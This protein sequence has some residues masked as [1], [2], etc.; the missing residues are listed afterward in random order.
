MGK[1]DPARSYVRSSPSRAPSSSHT[2]HVARHGAKELAFGVH[3]DTQEVF[4][5]SR[6]LTRSFLLNFV[7]LNSTPAHYKNLCPLYPRGTSSSPALTLAVRTLGPRL[8][9]ATRK[10]GSIDRDRLHSNPH[11][12]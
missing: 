12:H 4:I 9:L 8:H 11:L 1:H 5:L 7:A 10:N 3:E 2:L 6:M